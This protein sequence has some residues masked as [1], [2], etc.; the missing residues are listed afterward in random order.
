VNSA[1]DEPKSNGYRPV[2]LGIALVG[3][4]LF[5]AAAVIAA[6]TFE[7]HGSGAIVAAVVGAIVCWISAGAALIITVQSSGGPQAVPGM[8]LSIMVRTF[9]PLGVGIAASAMHSRLAE[10]GLFGYIV[11]L[12]LIGLVVETCVAVKLVSVRSRVPR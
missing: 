8:M 11:I 6:L 1:T 7:Q 4:V 3:F 10:A 5:I 12:Y 2:A 9:P